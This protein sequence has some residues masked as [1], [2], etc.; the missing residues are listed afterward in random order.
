MLEAVYLV[1]LIGAFVVIGVVSLFI[2]F[3]LFAGQE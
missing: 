2:L 3:R 1:I